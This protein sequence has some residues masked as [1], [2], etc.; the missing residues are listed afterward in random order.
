M[1]KDDR[2]ILSNQR[3]D[4]C[5]ALH[6]LLLEKEV[7]W[8]NE[9]RTWLKRQEIKVRVNTIAQILSSS[10]L[11]VTF[12]QTYVKVFKLRFIL[13][14]EKSVLIFS[15]EIDEGCMACRVKLAYNCGIGLQCRHGI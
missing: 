14:H 10:K 3:S 8:S 13:R 6:L 11:L 15:F 9:A 7:Y 12:H 4:C 5:C 2:L 1:S